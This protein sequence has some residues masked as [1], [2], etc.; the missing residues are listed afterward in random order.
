[1]KRPVCKVC[2]KSYCAVNYRKDD[3]VHY[4]SMCDSCIRKGRRIKPPAPKWKNKG[5]TKKLMCDRCGYRARYAGQTLVYHIDGD[6]NNCN[7]NNLNMFC[8]CVHRITSIFQC[9]QWHHNNLVQRHS[10]MLHY[11][12]TEALKA[13]LIK[14]ITYC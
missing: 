2:N 4:R 10:K 8:Y 9:W 13:Q 11:N 5:Y 7:L 1:M 3:V 14:L 6:L 12:L